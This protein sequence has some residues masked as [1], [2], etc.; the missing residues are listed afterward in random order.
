MYD[1]SCYLYTGGEVLSFV[2]FQFFIQR[3]TYYG[4]R[5]RADWNLKQL[6]GKCRYIG[7]IFHFHYSS[8]MS[9][10]LYTSL[11]SSRYT[12]PKQRYTVS[13]ISI[14]KLDRPDR[15]FRSYSDEFTINPPPSFGR[16][17]S[18]CPYYIL[19]GGGSSS[20]NNEI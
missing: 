8:T 10:F 12:G 6:P 14:P 15:K 2:I 9:P 11:L 5:A 13:W 18:L 16:G 7:P 1:E 4:L 20:R 17:W 3:I 19:N